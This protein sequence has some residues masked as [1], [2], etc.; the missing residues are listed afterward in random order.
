[1]TFAIG[2]PTISA[3]AKDAV[4]SAAMSVRLGDPFHFTGGKQRQPLPVTREPGKRLIRRQPL[5]IR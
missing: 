1:M 3:S 5:N 2:F 4:D